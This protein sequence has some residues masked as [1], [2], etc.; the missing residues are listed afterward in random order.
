MDS[1]RL[2]VLLYAAS[3][4][5]ALIY[6]VTWTRLLTLEMGHT[7]SAISIVLA[8]FMGVLSAGAWL[9]GRPGALQSHRLL[10]YAALDVVIALF[11]IA[12]PLSLAGVRTL[13]GA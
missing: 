2:F 11:A 10:L 3:G 8:A 12:F 4:T 5:A 13:L 1:R 6:E 9:G 7:V